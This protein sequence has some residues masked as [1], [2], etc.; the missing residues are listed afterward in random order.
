MRS[1]LLSRI[2]FQTGYGENNT[3][4]RYPRLPPLTPRLLVAQGWRR[5]LH[6][7]DRPDNR[8]KIFTSGKKQD[9]LGQLGQA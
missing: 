1:G 8:W 7:G 3:R 4:I 5:H 2:A 6:V 9:K